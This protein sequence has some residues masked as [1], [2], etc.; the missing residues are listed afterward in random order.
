[1]NG[2][3]GGDGGGYRASVMS[4]VS[5]FCATNVRDVSRGSSEDCDGSY[6]CCYFQTKP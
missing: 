1:M 5:L 4:R 3:G 6:H 2:G